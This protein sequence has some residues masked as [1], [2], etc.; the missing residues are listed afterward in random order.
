MKS[1]NGHGVDPGALATKLREM[2]PEVVKH[3]LSLSLSFDRDEDAWTVKL[4]KGRHE[5]TTLLEMTDTD[6]CF[7]GVQCIYVVKCGISWKTLSVANRLLC[8]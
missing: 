6:A 7:Q 2:Y 3:D 1:R 8:S 4:F 5:L